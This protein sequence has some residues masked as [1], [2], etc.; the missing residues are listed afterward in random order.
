MTQRKT[1]ELVLFRHAKSAWP[2][3]PDH[4]R[5]LAGRGIRA[6][7]VMGRWLR[8]AGL[9]PDLVLCST[10]RRARETW[11]FAQPGLA[12][13]P[14]VSFEDRI[15]GEDATELLA[16]IREVP[17]ATGRL[18]LIG[19][20]PAIEDLALMLAAPG[21][22]PG[23]PGP[24]PTGPGA[25]ERMRAKFPTAAI[26]V[27][28]TAGTWRAVAPGRARLTAFVTPRD[29]PMSSNGVG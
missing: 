23:A 25:L 5:P 10:A 29:V 13:T 9:V 22:D 4:E 7:P 1:R 21:P 18:L 20:N 12:A 26:A 14:P 24:D 6:A 2:D 8:D 15:Y 11:Q 27:L 3:V 28:Q 17:P 19:H 16:L